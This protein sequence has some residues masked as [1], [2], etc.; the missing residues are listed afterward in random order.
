MLENTAI[1]ENRDEKLSKF[2][3]LKK[4]I[5]HIENNISGQWQQI[6]HNK[7]HQPRKK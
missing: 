3:I 5:S 6:L 2:Q 1:R 7:K 4:G